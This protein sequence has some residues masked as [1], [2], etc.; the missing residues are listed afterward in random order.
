[1]EEYFSSYKPV[2]S[3][4]EEMTESNI[5]PIQYLLNG[6]IGLI[7][8]RIDAEENAPEWIITG[9]CTFLVSARQ[10]PM[11]KAMIETIMNGV[12]TLSSILTGKELIKTCISLASNLK[13]G[14]NEVEI[15][16]L[17]F[18]RA[19]YERLLL[20]NTITQT[21]SNPST[22]I[23]IAMGETTEWKELLSLYHPSCEKLLTSG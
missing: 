19:H 9:T 4:V 23:R 14:K 18:S 7:G 15:L 11:R 2:P 6:M 12:F 10:I 17:M 3:L 5:Y 13:E 16:F 1:M 20:N 21:W 8:S 22:A